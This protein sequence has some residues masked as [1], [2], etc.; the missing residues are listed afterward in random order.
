M[1]RKFRLST[2][3]EYVKKTWWAVV[4]CALVG[5]GIGALYGKA[6][7][8]DP[9]LCSIT[10]TVTIAYTNNTAFESSY[11]GMTGDNHTRDQSISNMNAKIYAVLI[12][13]PK[14]DDQ[15]KSKVK[16][17]LGPEYKNIKDDDLKEYYK[18]SGYTLT[19]T[20]ENKEDAV[21]IVTWFQDYISEAF[22][23]GGVAYE[24]IQQANAESI[25][26][27]V[28]FVTTIISNEKSDLVEN[29]SAPMS[30]YISALIG[31]VAGAVVYVVA[32]LLYFYFTPVLQSPDEFS[33]NFN[34]P[35]LE[36]DSDKNGYLNAALKVKT[37]HYDTP[38]VLAVNS[39]IDRDALARAFHTIGDRVLVA[40][41]DSVAVGKDVEIE[42]KDGYF[43][44]V[45]KDGTLNNL[46][47]ALVDV[48]EKFR[49]DF[50]VIIV[51]ATEEAQREDFMLLSSVADTSILKLKK[52]PS[53]RKT[54]KTFQDLSR[55]ESINICGVMF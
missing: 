43:A 26:N 12:T 45:K 24:V 36:E 1:E 31:A 20:L 32:V 23:S 28:K 47:S 39:A 8:K 19:V 40:D 2:I 42:E 5:L 50:D 46:K 33:D 3:W 38:F 54:A 30:W 15:I 53:Y 14:L 52:H 9:T 48:K 29:V 13:N 34:V 21:E 18:R 55:I 27:D 11:N 22:K 6:K 51:V 17:K 35:V 41:I 25:T 4:I 10:G 49:E 7:S 37:A 16:E 44:V